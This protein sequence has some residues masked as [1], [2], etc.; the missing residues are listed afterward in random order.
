M[1]AIPGPY[2]DEKGG[3]FDRGLCCRACV[4][5]TRTALHTGWDVPLRKYTRDYMKQHVQQ[6][7]PILR[8]G[9]GTYTHDSPR[10]QNF[11]SLP[12]LDASVDLCHKYEEITLE[13]FEVV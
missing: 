13:K 6:L 8:H 4:N 5:T 10:R 7:G 1:V 11:R 3:C 2:F 12:G 9:D